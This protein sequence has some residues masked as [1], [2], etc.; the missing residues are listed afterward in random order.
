M[1]EINPISPL[2]AFV[3]LEEPK[4][5]ENLQ[6]E[7][8]E[9][10]NYNNSY[11]SGLYIE[12][13]QAYKMASDYFALSEQYKCNNVKL[14]TLLEVAG[15]D[16]EKVKED[17]KDKVAKSKDK[18][19]KLKGKYKEAKEEIKR[20]ENV[21]KQL[22]IE[23]ESHDCK[24]CINHLIDLKNK[25]NEIQDLQQRIEELLSTNK[26]IKAEVEEL[27]KRLDTELDLN[28][29]VHAGNNQNSS[30][31][32]QLINDTESLSGSAKASSKLSIKRFDRKI[33]EAE[34]LTFNKLGADNFI[35]K[36]K[37]ELLLYDMKP[38]N[39]AVFLINAFTV[40][41]QSIHDGLT[42]LHGA[43]SEEI[44]FEEIFDLLRRHDNQVVRE[45]NAE[46]IIS[47]FKL[48]LENFSNINDYTTTILSNHEAYGK[49][50][51]KDKVLLL[52][53]PFDPEFK[54][55]FHRRFF[56]NYSNKE[57]ETMNYWTSKLSELV[58]ETISERTIV[59]EN[60]P[61]TN[62]NTSINGKKNGFNHSKHH[63]NNNSS[64]SNVSKESSTT[65]EIIDLR[66]GESKS[67][68]PSGGKS[69]N[70]KGDKGKSFNGRQ[71]AT[72]N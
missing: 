63:K 65:S 17:T 33:L 50:N 14:S 23:R 29:V 16:I 53:K 32:Q 1:S 30:T 66:P 41:N 49:K 67:N 64:Q 15:K 70:L 55:E 10:L 39:L 52:L 31:N 62:N 71:T 3:E 19:V 69:N 72:S 4:M 7:D 11:T 27:T 51:A 8:K 40:V 59:S 24:N 6:E 5:I 44:T 13:Q 20:L 35:R 48:D 56:Y 34:A 28:T 58:D 18:R 57:N 25:Q 47:K 21:N 9:K 22:E 26:S 43:R 54:K 68:Q 2:R 42:E 12:Y 61:N 46:A 60:K 45:S 38:L 36:R 37:A